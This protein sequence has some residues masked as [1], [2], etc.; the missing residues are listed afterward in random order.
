MSIDRSVALVGRPN[1]GKSRIFNRLVRRRVSIVHD[2][3]GVTRDVISAEIDGYLLLDT[4]GLGMKEASGPGG[5][6][7]AVE[8]QVGVAIEASGL[9]LFVV[10]G[11]AGLTPQDEIVADL[12]RRAGKPVVLLVN[13]IDNDREEANAHDFARLGFG[14]PVVFSAEHGRGEE[15]LREL[16]A[17]RLGPEPEAEA[18]EEVSER[19]R[20]CF[21][22]RPNVGKSSLCNALLRSERLIVSDTPGT[23]RDAVELDLDFRSD[24]GKVWPFRLHD[25]A[26]VRKATKLGSPVEYFST[27]RSESAVK[28]ADV[29]YLVLD[30]MEGVSKQDKNLAGMIMR[31]YRGFVILVN[32]WDLAVD[33]FEA[34]TLEGYETERE[35]RESYAA[36][37]RKEL[38]FHP[39]SPVLFVSALRGMEIERMLKAARR[40]HYLIHRKLP[41]G[42][43]N[44]LMISLAEKRPASAKQGTRFRIYY[45]VQTGT[46]PITVRLFCN[47][48]EKL[49]DP[50]RRYLEGGIGREFDLAGCPIKFELVGKPPRD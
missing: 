24:E 36:S 25:T 10:D 18:E 42:R 16:I 32:K 12:L 45:A 31:A 5:I 33:S 21:A 2:Q 20:I 19:I 15:T 50:Y 38:F 34:G 49:E 13:K 41:T 26:G 43:L 9:I 28:R 37:V 22:G 8:V 35:F 7:A 39:E 48:A 17:E 30:A 29:V 1:V 3:P 11:K 27:L 4:G 14:D 46:N 44:R 47:R 6:A 40:I 23:T